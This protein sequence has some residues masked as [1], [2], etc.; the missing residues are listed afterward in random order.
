M[1]ALADRVLSPEILYGVKMLLG[2]GLT[3]YQVAGAV[4]SMMQES[5]LNTQA[6]NGADPNGGSLGLAQMNGPRLE[7]LARMAE[8]AGTSIDD[9]YVQWDHIG[10]EL[11]S[12]ESRALAK[13][14][15]AK[16]LGEATRV[17][18]D[19][20]ERPAQS[21]ARH[22]R[23]AQFADMVANT[24]GIAGADNTT[25][26]QLLD[27]SILRQT[28]GE[29]SQQR[30]RPDGSA[31]ADAKYQEGRTAGGLADVLGGMLGAVG[32]GPATSALGAALGNDSG[33][34]GNTG[35]MLGGAVGGIPGAIMG[36]LLGHI[37]DSV[38]GKKTAQ[39]G[40]QGDAS[41]VQNTSAP[42]TPSMLDSIESAIGGLFGGSAA[43]PA[44]KDDA[45]H[46]S[47]T[48]TATSAGDTVGSAARTAGKTDS[49]VANAS[50]RSGASLNQRRASRSS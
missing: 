4:G 32:G 23:R 12:T 5:G 48:A 29:G 19:Y 17:W 50:K 21:A 3:E 47:K 16:T 6:Y 26:P 44:Q 1:T 35:A 49:K 42:E 43:R 10:Q 34:W 13:L 22:D 2:L 33:A 38:S 37:A 31:L 20:F 18:T 7:E 8:A 40:Q 15:E 25:D 28:L 11:L 46:D 41:Q 24:W 39:G 45:T 27:G 9:P 14:K 36:S 30:N